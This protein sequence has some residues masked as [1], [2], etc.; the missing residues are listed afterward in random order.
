MEG[1]LSLQHAKCCC[2]GRYEVEQQKDTCEGTGKEEKTGRDTHSFSWK[3][4]EGYFRRGTARVCPVWF[5]SLSHREIALQ[6]TKS[7]ECF[8]AFLFFDLSVAF[9]LASC[10]HF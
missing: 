6:I 7:R 10:F 2:R 5:M 9:G 8:P 3:E 1:I 4:A